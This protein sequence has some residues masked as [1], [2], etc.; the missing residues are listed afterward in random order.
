MVNVSI[1]RFWRCLQDLPPRLHF[2]T[3]FDFH[4]HGHVLENASS[5]LD[6]ETAPNGVESSAHRLTNG[7]SSA[8]AK[9]HHQ[10]IRCKG[11]LY[12]SLQGGLHVWWQFKLLLRLRRSLSLCSTITL[13]RR[14][15]FACC[16][17]LWV[18]YFSSVR[19]AYKENRKFYLCTYLPSQKNFGKFLFSVIVKISSSYRTIIQYSLDKSHD[20]IMLHL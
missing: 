6:C 13:R 3:C 4:S 17:C 16:S 9:A 12:C 18:Y 8:G 5:L 1:K 20:L 7:L 14:R 11:H 2:S 19:T 10:V 15:V